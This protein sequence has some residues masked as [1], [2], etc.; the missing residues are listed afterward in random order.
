[1]AV[2]LAGFDEIATFAHQVGR[3]IDGVR[4]SEVEVPSYFPDLIISV[5]SQITRLAE[6]NGRNNPTLIAETEKILNDF[7]NLNNNLG[8]ATLGLNL[9]GVEGAQIHESPQ[10]S[11]SKPGAGDRG[12]GLNDLR[13]L[14]VDDELS[15]RI[16]LQ[17]LVADFGT[18]HIAFDGY[19]AFLAYRR[20][21]VERMPYDVVF[22]DIL[23]PFLDGRSV[24]RA[25][26]RF[27]STYEISKPCKIF[28][29]SSLDEPCVIEDMLS[30]KM[31]DAYLVKPIMKNMIE[32]CL[33]EGINIDKPV[34]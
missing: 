29:T 26:R 27:E 10:F 1:M 25:I 4:K 8:D 2:F 16:I 28:M 21:H 13:F 23:M 18:S 30:A 20:S 6:N 19:E 33:M 7:A 14:I 15:S 3:T 11:A 5:C 17:D 31:C 24:A 12:K 34:C 22:L 9:S 32:N